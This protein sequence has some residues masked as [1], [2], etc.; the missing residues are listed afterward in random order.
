MMLLLVL[1][2]LM[3]WMER[4]SHLLLL[5]I[6]HHVLHHWLRKS[7]DI[8]VDALLESVQARQVF[9]GR[10]WLTRSWRSTGK[11]VKVATFSHKEGRRLELERERVV[12]LQA[13][14][15]GFAYF[16]AGKNILLESFVIIDTVRAV[17]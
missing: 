17:R 1:L 7:A 2:M 10:R 13:W 3:L 12:K 15:S 11:I 5:V 16:K 6:V 4:R 14:H 8:H 9:F